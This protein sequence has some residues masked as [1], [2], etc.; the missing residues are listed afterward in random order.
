MPRDSSATRQFILSA[1][2]ELFYAEGFHPVTVDAIAEKA[3]VTKKTLYYHFRSKDELIAAYLDERDRPTFKRYQK[4]AGEDGPIAERV[5]RIFDH[6]SQ[7]VRTRSW[8]GCGF[9]RA[10]SE[11]A[12]MPGHPAVRIA[13]THKLRFEAWLAEALEAESYANSKVLAQAL[14]ILIDGTVAQ[15]LLHRSHVYADAAKSAARIML[16]EA[17]ELPQAAR[18]AKSEP[19]P[20]PV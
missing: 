5:D 13:R 14:V 1:A 18:P 8:R 9:I 7:A 4:V 11:L 12:N 10:A 6:L 16:N 2:D 19:V 17:E 20:C 15:M 3:G